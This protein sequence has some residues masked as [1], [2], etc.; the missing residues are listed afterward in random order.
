M[1]HIDSRTRS[2]SEGS[3]NDVFHLVSFRTRGLHSAPTS[4]IRHGLRQVVVYQF[5]ANVQL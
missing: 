4:F 5:G 1:K 2:T 3:P